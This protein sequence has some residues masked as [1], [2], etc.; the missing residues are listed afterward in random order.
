MA[1]R[2]IGNT[3]L[4]QAGGGA[5]R[6]FV[7]IQRPKVKSAIF[8]PLNPVSAA[9]ARRAVFGTEDIVIARADVSPRTLRTGT[10]ASAPSRRFRLSG[11]TSGSA[12]SDSLQFERR[13]TAATTTRARGRRAGDVPR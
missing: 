12:A 10:S 6:S 7:R 11:E 4:M 9:A 8:D 2:K 5:E 13:A 1:A 3:N